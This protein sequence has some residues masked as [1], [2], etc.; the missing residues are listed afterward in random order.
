M[1]MFGPRVEYFQ[2][3]GQQIAIQFLCLINCAGPMRCDD[4]V[5]TNESLEQFDE[6][7]QANSVQIG[8]MSGV[9][10]TEKAD[11]GHWGRGGQCAGIVVH[12]I[13]N[14]TGNVLKME[15]ILEF[16]IKYL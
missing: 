14:A 10:Q 1:E 12:G 2:A 6:W 11:D 13:M 8:G 16:N 7:S 9:H 15:K 3:N 5:F 4:H